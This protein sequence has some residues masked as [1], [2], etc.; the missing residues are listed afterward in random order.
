LV[1]TIPNV[2]LTIF[3]L[4][5]DVAIKFADVIIQTDQPSKVVKAIKINHS[6]RKIV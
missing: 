3:G 5:N 2:G 6:T 1:V 4:G